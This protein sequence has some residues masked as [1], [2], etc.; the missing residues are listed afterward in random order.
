MDI[1]KVKKLIELLEESGIDE[2]EIHEGEESVR[3]SRHSKQM[4]VQQ[5]VYAPAPAPVAAPAPAAAPAASESAPAAP[6]LNGTVVRSPMV[7]TFYRASSP[8]AK[9]FVDVG[10]TVKKGDILCIVEAMKMMNHI[11]AETSGTIESVLVE[12]GHPVEFDQP[13]FTIV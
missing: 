9:P 10:Q 7:G 5:P 2:L 12:N 8:E 3:I 13:L 4:A 11:E 1:R 6:K